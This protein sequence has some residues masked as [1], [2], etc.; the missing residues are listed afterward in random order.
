MNKGRNFEWIMKF[1]PFYFTWIYRSN[2]A[3]EN[4]RVKIKSMRYEGKG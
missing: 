4:L 1:L 2:F 3:L